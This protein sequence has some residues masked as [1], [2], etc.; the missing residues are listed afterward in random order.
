MAYRIA[1][2]Y[3]ASCSCAN[4][5]PCPVDQRPN[6]PNGECRGAAVFGIKEGN[7]DDVDLSGVNF[8]L[9]NF[10]PSNI[11]AGNWKVGI[12]VDD[13]ASDEQAAAVDRIISGEEGGPFG[14]FK[15]LIGEYIG[16]ERASVGISDGATPSIS[17][18]GMTDV[19]FEPFTGPDGSPTTVRGAMFGFAREYRIG[20][21][22]GS[23]DGFDLSFEP[24]YGEHAEFEFSTELAGELHPR[25]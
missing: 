14:D 23:S 19:R 12:V 18:G 21:T 22:S 3:V 10:F 16:M 4:I 2:T 5:C 15:P 1:G 9:Y 6:T 11:T 20:K 25:A 13:G 17:V 7:L 24:D 8:A